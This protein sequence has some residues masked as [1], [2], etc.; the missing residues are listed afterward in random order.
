MAWTI[1]LNGE[2]HQTEANTI[3]ELVQ[4]LG[5]ADQA[6]AVEHN[7]QIVPK[8]AHD[9]TALAEGDRIELVTLVGGGGTIRNL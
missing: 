5:Y 4:E 1:T 8:K 6:V 3:G 9:Q 2:P 7:E